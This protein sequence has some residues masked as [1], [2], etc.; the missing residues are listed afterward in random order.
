D[1][2][3][4]LYELDDNVAITVLT[5]EEIDD[6]SSAEIS[7][8]SLEDLAAAKKEILAYNSKIPDKNDK[9]TTK[10]GDNVKAYVTY[11]KKSSAEYPVIDTI[12]VIVNPDEP[13]EYLDLK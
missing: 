12:V 10:Y 2:T 7:V 6:I 13:E 9:L 3:F 11:T 1:E 8:L 5:L 4:V